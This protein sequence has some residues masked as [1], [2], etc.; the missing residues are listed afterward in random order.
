M[1]D[2]ELISEVTVIRSCMDKLYCAY[3]TDF[4]NLRIIAH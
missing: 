1:T 2:T 4:L 3:L